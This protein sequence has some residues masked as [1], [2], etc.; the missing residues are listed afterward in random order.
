MMNYDILSTAGV[1]EIAVSE[2][3]TV[4]SHS[5]PILSNDPSFAFEYKAYSEGVVAVKLEV[6]QSNSLPATEGTADSNW[7][8]PDDAPEFNE[9]L[10]DEL[11]H[12]KA[13][14]ITPTRFARFK[15]TGLALNDASTKLTKL[16]MNV[17]R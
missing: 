17:M 11:I 9:S 6:E 7:C 3:S 16:S 1:S 2:Q 5:F 8:I 13:Y 12:F 14:P 4:Y 15:I 10:Q